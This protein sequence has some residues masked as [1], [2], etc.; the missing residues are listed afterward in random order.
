MYVGMSNHAAWQV[1]Q[2]LWLCDQ[3]R[4]T[5]PV[6]MQCPYNLVTR[7]IEQEFLPLCREFSL[8]VTVYNPLA[9]GLLTGKHDRT[10]PPREDTRFDRDDQYYNRYWLDSH[11]DA[12]ADL[13][14]I[15]D[16][17]GKKP[18][19]LALQWLAAQ[20]VVDAI[21]LGASRMEQLEQNLSAWDGVLDQDTL[22]A[23]D[24]VW[25]G[26]RGDT[27]RYNR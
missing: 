10:R 8:G 22:Q 15:A 16:Q 27:F 24:R 4:L 23:C 18:V 20:E 6:V 12:L 9:G 21:I 19:E 11:F 2:A 14:G 17:A 3:H 1:C 7:G 5:P 13:V 26:L 25:A